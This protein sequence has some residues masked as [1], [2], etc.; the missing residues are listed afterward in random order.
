MRSLAGGFSTPA[1][2]ALLDP[3]DGNLL[4]YAGSQASVG[5]DCTDDL[6][7]S[8]DMVST[9]YIRDLA[10]DVEHVLSPPSGIT[11]NIAAHRNNFV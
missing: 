2:H 9:G 8:Q 1:L 5:I 6:L 11:F 3:N 10:S 4:S 7:T